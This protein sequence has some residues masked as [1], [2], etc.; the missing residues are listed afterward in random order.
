MVNY[1]SFAIRNLKRRGIRSWLTLLGIF[2]GITAV[3]ALISLG[4][5][6]KAAVNS[7]F[8]VESTQVITVQATGLNGFGPPGSG[9][10]NPLTEDEAEEIEDISGVEVVIPRKIEQVKFEFNNNVKFPYAMDVPRGKEK[11]VEE[12]LGINT[13]E[14]NFLRQNDRKKAILGYNFKHEDKNNLGKTLER[15]DRI[16]VENQTFSVAG[17][18]EKQGSFIFDNIVAVHSNELKDLK[19]YGEKVDI[20]AVKVNSK[21]PE[22]MEKVKQNIEELLRDRRNVEKGKEDFSVETPEAVLEDVNNILAGIQAFIIIIASI[23]IFIGAVGITNTMT[24]SVLER[25]REIGIM[26]AIGAENKDIFF[27]FLVE[28]GM[29][30]FIGGLVGALTGM[31]IGMLGIS[32]INNFV[33][34]EVKMQ[35]DF[36]LFGFALMGSFLIGSVA[37]II[38]AYTASRKSPVESIRT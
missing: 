18:L 29:L 34:S 3:V 26:K 28:S 4:G 10:T 36:V 22:L 12:L 33:G 9:V 14:G 27:Q 35:V 8:G 20:I 37:G 30:G 25:T 5:G 21:D 6:L 19:N 16:K 15:G 23:S 17:I 7:Q 24:T 1:F 2:I 38:P 11:Y 13:L 31:G 32:A